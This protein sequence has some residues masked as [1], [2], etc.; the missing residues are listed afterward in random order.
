MRRIPHLG[1]QEV[2]SLTHQIGWLGI[3]EWLEV[4]GGG[5]GRSE[6]KVKPIDP[7][8]CVVFCHQRSAIT[9][10]AKAAR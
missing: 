8:S 3:L 9:R 6:F 4:G 10:E 1:Q 2:N 7:V 5:A